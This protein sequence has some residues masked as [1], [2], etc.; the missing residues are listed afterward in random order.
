MRYRLLGETGLRVSELCLGAMTFGEAWG[1]MAS[2]PEAA[3]AM[4]TAYAEAGGNFIDT[5]NNYQKGQSELLVGDF[6]HADR[7]RWVLASKYTL[8]MQPGDPNAWGNHRKNLV[9]S[10]EASLK[11][12]RTDYLDLL[13]VHIW[14]FSTSPEEVMR[15][16]EDLTRAGKI[17]HVGASDTPAWMVSQATTLARLR[18]WNPFCAIQV[19]YSLLQ[20]DV[21]RELVPMSRSLDLGVLAFSP[22]AAGV[23]SGKFLGQTPDS[24]RSDWV[25]RRLADPRTGEVLKVVLDISS[26]CNRTPSQVSLAWLRQR[27]GLVIPI[28]G[29]RTAAQLQDNLA[30]VDLALT[31]DQ[32]QRLDQVSAPEGTFIRGMWDNAYLVDAF[33][34][35]GTLGSIEPW[36]RDI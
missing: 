22:L 34:T 1:P 24:G 2:G 15:G 11:R 20:R 29:A 7:D 27:E 19:E 30:S 3:K 4:M 21:E 16:L 17:L 31:A 5:A 25:A 10:V 32:L 14:D 8:C 36:R 13:W 6:I 23:L 33:I 12:L 35:G 9:R 26:A 28:L 18:G